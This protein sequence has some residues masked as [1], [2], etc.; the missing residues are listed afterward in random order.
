M[1]VDIWI[2]FWPSLEALMNPA[3]LFWALAY[4]DLEFFHQPRRIFDHVVA[5]EVLER[6]ADIQDVS[7]V[8]W[9]PASRQ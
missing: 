2:R 9:K 4:I 8:I 5:G 7:R 6:S 1:L 3:I